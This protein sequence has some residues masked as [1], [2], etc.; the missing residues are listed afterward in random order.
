MYPLYRS[1]F[2]LVKMS[3]IEDCIVR[4]GLYFRSFILFALKRLHAQQAHKQLKHDMNI[5]IKIIIGR[6]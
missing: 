6:L 4:D 3:N 2:L 1:V 5:V